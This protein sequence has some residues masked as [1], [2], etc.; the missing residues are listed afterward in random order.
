MNSSQAIRTR[1]RA[2]PA[3]KRSGSVPSRLCLPDLRLFYASNTG[4]AVHRVFMT[5]SQPGATSHASGPTLSMTSR[6]LD[7]SPNPRSTP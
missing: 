5:R 7:S 3:V 1:C 2:A 6:Q 4:C